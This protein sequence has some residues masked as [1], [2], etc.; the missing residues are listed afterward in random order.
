MLAEI[1][2]RSLQLSGESQ[3]KGL[4]EVFDKKYMIPLDFDLIATHAPLYK[5]PI[6][7]DIIFEISLA[8]K[9][10]IIVA[11]VIANM[12]YKLENICME[13]ETVTDKTIASQLTAN[14]NSGFSFFYDYVDLS[15]TVNV[16]A[17]DTLINENMN[18]PRRSIKGIL[19][20]FVSNYADGKRDSE[21][22]ENPEITN[23]KVTIEGVANKVFA[24]GMRTMDQWKEA[25]RF[26]MNEHMKTTHDS[27][28]TMEKFYTDNKFGLW[29]DLRTTH[30]NTLHGSGKTLT[31]TKDGIQLAITKKSGKGPYKMYIYVVSDAQ[32]NSISS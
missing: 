11:D 9:E 12:S 1:L 7:E 13:Y 21:K 24:E 17:N 25:Q 29:L 14:Y 26:F 32:V 5:F 23:V 18:F 15:K 2:L 27:F 3:D 19:L 31:N 22:F 20:L 8:P 16:L 10:D 6:Q 4:K 30:D 28:M